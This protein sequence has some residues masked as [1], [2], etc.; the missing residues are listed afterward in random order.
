MR[1]LR[2]ALVLG[3]TSSAAALTLGSSASSGSGTHTKAAITRRGALTLGAAIATAPPTLPAFASVKEKK[4]DKFDS[5]KK[6]DVSKFEKGT[7]GVASASFDEN[8]TVKR[9]R[10]KNGGLALDTDG[11]KI[12]Q[13]NRNRPPEELGLKQWSGE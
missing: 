10:D 1:V 8:D 5:S 6:V 13:A 12:V 4:T 3:L 11:R 7:R 9:N 2:V